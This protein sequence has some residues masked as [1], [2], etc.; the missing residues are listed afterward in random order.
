MVQALFAWQHRFDKPGA[1]LIQVIADSTFNQFTPLLPS[2]AVGTVSARSLIES[3]RKLLLPL[4]GSF[5]YGKAVDVVM[6][7]RLLE[8]EVPASPDGDKKRVYV[9]YDK[10]VIAVG[11]VSASHGVPGLENCFQLKTIE[12]AQKIR[13]RI[14]GMRPPYLSCMDSTN[15]GQFA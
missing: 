13:R 6:G 15:N 7:E 9:P 2:A 8:V 1:S 4:R 3:V 12:D 14:I 10:L 5:I 11:S